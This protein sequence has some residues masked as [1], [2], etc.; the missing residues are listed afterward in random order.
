MSDL[1]QKGKYYDYIF[2]D[3]NMPVMNGIEATK[4]MREM[5]KQGEINLNHTLIYMHSAI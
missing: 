3:I 2:M 4:L 5:N 1:H